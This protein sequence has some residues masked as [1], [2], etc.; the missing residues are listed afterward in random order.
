MHKR[1]FCCSF[2]DERGD[3]LEVVVVVVDDADADAFTD[4]LAWIAESEYCVLN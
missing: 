1:W 3:E 2:E 4:S